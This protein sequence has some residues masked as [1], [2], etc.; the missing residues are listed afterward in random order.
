MENIIS[1]IF[2]YIT[3]IIIFTMLGILFPPY[4]DNP[5]SI[6]M[7]II[8]VFLIFFALLMTLIILRPAIKSQYIIKIF[9][10]H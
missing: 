2:V 1:T 4:H 6:F 8:I 7:S 5:F 3:S 9:I 10:L